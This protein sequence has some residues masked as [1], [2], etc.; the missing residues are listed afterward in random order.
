VELKKSGLR[1]S[2]GPEGSLLAQLKIQSVPRNKVLV[3]Q[4]VDKK[5]VKDIKESVNQGIEKTFQM[6][7]GGLIAM[8]RRIYL[9]DYKTLKDEV[10]R[11]THESQFATHPRSTKMYKDLKEY[12]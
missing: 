2:V 1:L 11:E 7:S 6:L 5:K 8:A 9:P 10:L 3:A 4:Q 12:Y